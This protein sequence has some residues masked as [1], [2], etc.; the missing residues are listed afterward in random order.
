MNRLWNNIFIK[1]KYGQVRSGW[2]IL[3]VMAAYYLL[4]YFGSNGILICLRKLLVETGDLDPVTGQLSEFAEWLDAKVLFTVF[5]VFSDVLMTAVPV[6]AWKYVMRHPL[7]GLGLRPGNQDRKEGCAGMLLGIVNCSV[8]FLIVITVGEGRVVSGPELSQPA[9]WWVFVFAVVAVGEEVM[10]RGFL[11]GA[12]RRCRNIYVIALVPSVVFGCIHLGNPN[13]TLLS[14]LN[15]ILVGVLFSYMYIRSGNLRMCIGYHFTWNT[16]QGVVLGMPVSGLDIPGI[17]TTQ[18]A[19]NN[20]LN[21][22]MFGIEGGILTTL[23]TLAS[24]VFVRYYYRDSR[25]DFI[26]DTAVRPLFG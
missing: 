10:N 21:G 18:F 3:T 19:Q 26:N 25:Y 6:V 14:V 12:L 22:G 11:M 1:N 13:V 20:L 9:V 16:L 4:Q 23:G 17:F 24:F 7:G 8:I 5:Q 2:I 15:I